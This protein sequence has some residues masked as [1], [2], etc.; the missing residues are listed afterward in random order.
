MGRGDDRVVGEELIYC[1]NCTGR[2]GDNRREA[3]AQLF[4]ASATGGLPEKFATTELNWISKEVVQGSPT[5]AEVW[6]VIEEYVTRCQMRYCGA[7]P[8]LIAHNLKLDIGFL[9]NELMRIG[10]SLPRWDFACSMEDVA[11][12]V[13]RGAPANVAVL[14]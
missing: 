5:F 4:V 9:R 1:G 8:L 10:H 12:K 7:R 2:A 11:K 14:I 13:W 3:D 6:L